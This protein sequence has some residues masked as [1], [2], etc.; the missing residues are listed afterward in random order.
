MYLN[1]R[2]LFYGAFQKIKERQ[3][4]PIICGGTGMYLEAV[5]EGYKM[6]KVP[7]NKA[8]RIELEEKEMEELIVILKQFAQLHNTTDTTSKKRIIRAI[9]IAKYQQKHKTDY[10]ELKPLN[11]LL[12]GIEFSRDER[13]ARI[14]ERLHARL[15]EGM[16]A[17]VQQI[18]DSGVS[19]DDLL[20]YGLEYKFITQHLI[21]ELSY[22][23]MVSK[24]N[25]AIHQFAKRQMT[26][27]RRMEK[28]GYSIHWID[29][30]LPTHE[31][32]EKVLKL[33]KL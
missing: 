10:S 29:G 3:H 19:S 17:E 22:K 7:Q 11:S 4:L 31:K 20:F 1:I 12:I 18:L 8:L 15:H 24:L 9:E 26:W 16:V 28:K 14:T 33:F 21:G 32:V 13:R 2:I 30:N 25:T 23:E 5:L 6:A 27:F